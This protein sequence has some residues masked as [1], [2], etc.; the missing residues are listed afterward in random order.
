MYFNIQTDSDLVNPSNITQVIP[1]TL[2]RKYL[3][4]FRFALI[5]IILLVIVIAVYITTNKQKEAYQSKVIVELQEQ[6]KLFY[7]TYL[8]DIKGRYIQLYTSTDKIESITVND[9]IYDKN[10]MNL[11]KYEDMFLF[12]IDLIRD[13]AIK[14][15]HIKYSKD[16]KIIK[17]SN[18]VIR[19]KDNWILSNNTLSK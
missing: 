5:I 11:S 1:D 18:I 8:T 16:S 12:T 19:D 3:V 14:S 2:N 15:I 9:F 7:I 4:F 17:N 10:K 6:Y 13:R